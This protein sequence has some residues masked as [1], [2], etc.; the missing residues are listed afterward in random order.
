M[1]FLPALCDRFFVQGKRYLCVFADDLGAQC[2]NRLKVLL[3]FLPPTVL[4][5]PPNKY[6]VAVDRSTL[7]I[8]K[9]VGVFANQSLI[10]LL[11]F[12]IKRLE[13]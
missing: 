7:Q 3:F 11:Q 1:R 6:L 12:G 10:F 2:R 4:P 8:G 13:V 9:Q 5:L